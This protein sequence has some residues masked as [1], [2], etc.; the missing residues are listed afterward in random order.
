MDSGVIDVSGVPEPVIWTTAGGLG[1]LA[2][3][4][5][6]LFLRRTVS[7]DNHDI[8]ADRS[9]SD[10][11]AR[12]ETEVKH[13]TERAD[14][15]NARADR[16]FD[17]RNKAIERAADA[18]SKVAALELQV[19]SL[20]DEVHRLQGMLIEFQRTGLFRAPPL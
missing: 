4:L 15:A 18:V 8:R 12:L 20:G 7:R 14:H 13:Q 3:S 16:A 5:I 17:E 2:L 1:T 10:Q 9:G 11:F 19:K 6:G